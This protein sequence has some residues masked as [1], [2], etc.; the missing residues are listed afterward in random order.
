[1]TVDVGAWL[2]QLGLE[3]YEPAFQDHEI[4]W[5]VLP[6]LTEADLETL[7]IPLGPRKKLLKAIAMLAAAGAPAA[8][9][10]EAKRTTIAPHAAERRQLT[11]MFVDLVGS[12]VLAARLDPEEM[13]EVLRRYQA[14]V[15]AAIGRFEGHI[16]KY[17]GDGV[18]AYF[19]WPRAHEDAA[20]RAVRAAL[21]IE[22]AVAGLDAPEQLQ[23][24]IGIATGLVV[25]GDPIG[26]GAAREETVVGETPNLAAR[27]QALAEPGHIVVAD[28][29]RRLLGGLFELEDLGLRA[30]KG[31]DR[32]VVVFRVLRESNAEARFEARQGAM[33]RLVGREQ[34]LGLLL[35][36]W[37]LARAA[38]GQVVL[39]SGEAGIGKSRLTL[40]LRE[41]LLQERHTSLLYFCSPHHTNS[42]LYPVIAQFERAAG[43]VRDDPPAAHLA[44]LKALLP[45]GGDDGEA[46]TLLA[47]LLGLP[48]ECRERPELTPQ[49]RRMR[50]F[51]AFLA[52]LEGWAAKQTVLVVLEDAHWLDPTSLELFGLAIKRIQR[53][54]VLL[55]VTHRPEFEPPWRGYPHVAR[56]TLNRLARVQAHTMVGHLT[57]GR[58]LPAAVLEPIL[59]KTDGVPLFVEELTKT[60]LE[61]GLLREVDG[62]WQLAGPLPPLAIPE[63]LQGSL[64]A[65]LDR[66]APVKE[67]A[68][69]GACIGREF[70]YALLAAVADRPEAELRSSL[71]Q[72]L[73]GELL[74]RR[75]TPPAASY[76]F[77]HA[78]VQEAAYQSLLKSRRT[79]LHAR[80]AEVLERQFPEVV[81][82]EPELLAHHLSLGGLHAKAI[83]YWRRAGLQAVSRSAVIEAIDI[84]RTA[85]EQLKLVPEQAA[86]E[87]DLQLALGGALAAAH[88]HGVP[89]TGEA[90]ARAV[91]L[92][93]T[94]GRS[95][96]L[97]PALDGLL[98]CHFSRGELPK[99]IELSEDFLTLAL[100][101]QA[102]APTVIAHMDS[103]ILRLS[104]GE[105]ETA[106]KHFQE[107]LA[108]Y[109]ANAHSSLKLTYNY[110]PRVISLGYLAWV[111]LALGYPDQ[112]LMHSQKSIA[113]ACAIRHPLSLGFALARAT[114]VQHLRR[115]VAAADETASRLQALAIEQGFGTYVTVADFYR[116]WGILQRGEAE[117][118]RT[119]L[120]RSY[121]TFLANRDEDFLP[122]NL[123]LVAEAHV[124]VGDTDMALELVSEGL[125]RIERNREG[126]FAAELHRLHGEMLLRLGAADHAR[127]GMALRRAL[128]VAREQGAK[129][130]ELRA[131]TSLAQLWR[132]QGRR[133]EAHGLLA[134]IY[135]W[136]TEGFDT[137]DLKEAKALLDALA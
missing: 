92:C 58:L 12:T 117:E 88:G 18:L 2:R 125:R 115:E 16:A 22:E 91:E 103:G 76:V 118:G 8:S 41:H 13:G 111:L 78:L 71:D 100:Q 57:G 4:D 34:E 85:L 65:R 11:V 129:W 96:A 86:L 83:D 67:V 97:F 64:L 52:Q 104:L 130:W 105:L 3:R 82:G 116:G 53:L 112:A 49:Q 32:A 24:R 110:D 37:A 17:M 98:T 10:V 28:G 20:E 69:I 95:D 33:L 61:S 56:L 134:P 101:Q 75:G 120:S 14:A 21:A 108:T 106:R 136:F 77:K 87:L 126:W 44:K 5:E 46:T 132:D 99:A 59:A 84:F 66:L 107:V 121:A 135:G 23:A 93:R 68:Q 7:E 26:E 29:T 30:L 36:R 94:T 137:K 25:V 73:G 74:F 27:L 102:I 109:D 123:S 89:D 47:E 81:R 131:A 50:T 79:I 48:V 35:D 70:S 128:E 40:A 19:G 55:V 31:F 62:G 113:E 38:E 1:L 90:Y 63:T 80:I 45:K 119:V 114:A 42:A 6:E 124:L 127:A 9:E 54:P 39:L 51:Q 60:V 43:F 122:Y 15:A 133:S 72:L